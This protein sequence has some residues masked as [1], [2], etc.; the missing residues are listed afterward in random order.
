MTVMSRPLGVGQSMPEALKVGDLPSLPVLGSENASIQFG[1][2]L[3]LA[4]PVMNDIGGSASAWWN[5][6][7]AEV[8]ALYG[9]WLMASPLQRLRLKP[10][11]RVLDATGQRIEMKAVNMLLQVLP[12]MIKKD[13]VATRSLTSTSILF[14]LYTLYQPGGGA[15]RAGLLKSISDPKVPSNVQEIASSLRQWRR[16]V[17]R[18]EELQITLPDASILMLAMSKFA[19]ALGKSGGVQVTYR[20]AGVRQELK[21]D[22]RPEHYTIKELAE[23]LQAEAEELSL[24]TGP[25][26]TSLATTTA[27]GG[28]PVVKAMNVGSGAG[29]QDGDRSA[30]K[31][32]CKFWKSEDGCRKGQ[33]CSYG[34]DTADMKGRCFGCG[35]T[36]HVKKECPVRRPGDGN[37]G[38]GKDAKKTAKLKSGRDPPVNEGVKGSGA[39][40][41]EKDPITKPEA[42]EEAMA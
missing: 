8:D 13:V 15:E 7:L 3:V 17:S 1:D 12:E 35:A 31:P 23:Y 37:G 21:V 30:M 2:W 26:P 42:L 27:G 29:G 41:V 36:S 39:V 24:A 14:R 5:D 34:H 33:D 22:Y 40:V 6:L 18:A 25:K 20:I 9:E 28:G 4:R 38:F 32:A 16:C 10:H 19:D 11:Q